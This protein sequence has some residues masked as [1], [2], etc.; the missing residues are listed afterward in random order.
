MNG[1]EF[2]KLYE[3]EQVSC[4]RFCIKLNDDNLNTTLKYVWIMLRLA[5]IRLIAENSIRAV[6]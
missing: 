6:P 5:F 1:L 4:Q 3:I 2:D